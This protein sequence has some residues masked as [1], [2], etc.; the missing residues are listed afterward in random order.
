MSDST[1]TSK[2]QSLALDTVEDLKLRELT[3]RDDEL[4]TSLQLWMK[5]NKVSVSEVLRLIGNVA[6][7]VGLNMESLLDSE[8]LPS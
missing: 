5:V 8:G 4:L 2:T 1:G 7:D 6:L 3:V